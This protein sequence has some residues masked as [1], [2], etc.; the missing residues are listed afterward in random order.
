M[1]GNSTIKYSTN[2]TVNSDLYNSVKN[3]MSSEQIECFKKMGQECYDIDFENPHTP[4][5]FQLKYIMQ[6]LKS[7]LFYD[8]LLD[9]E[10]NL[11]IKMYGKDWKT[12]TDKMIENQNKR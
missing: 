10:T 12:I 8:D 11:L 6:G 3:K 1:K 4:E 2:L 5:E 9:E 7:G